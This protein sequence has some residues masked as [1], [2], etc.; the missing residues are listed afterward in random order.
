MRA[1]APTGLARRSLAAF[2]LEL[3]IHAHA[4]A[5]EV[6]DLVQLE[7]PV[8]RLGAVVRDDQ[9][10]TR[11]KPDVRLDLIAREVDRLLERGDG[12]VRSVSFRAAVAN[13]PHARSLSRPSGRILPLLQFPP[14]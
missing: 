13:T 9:R 7:Q 2:A 5:T 6:E 11:H 8:T 14:V 12:V 10:A 4:A 1:D 3:H